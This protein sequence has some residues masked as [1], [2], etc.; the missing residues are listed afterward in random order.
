ML[1]DLRAEQPSAVAI[2]GRSESPVLL[3]A[4]AS[5]RARELLDEIGFNVQVVGKGLPASIQIGWLRVVT[6]MSGFGKI[7]RRTDRDITVI[8]FRPHLPV[9]V[10]TFR[11]PIQRARTLYF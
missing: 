4:A 9:M 11:G 10:V 7:R 8:D 3:A 1:R 6:R 5:R 2:T